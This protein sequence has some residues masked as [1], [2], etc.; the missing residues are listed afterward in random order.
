MAKYKK[1][2]KHVSDPLKKE[3]QELDLK[4]V[5]DNKYVKIIVLS[6]FVF[7]F[8]LYSNTLNH[9]YALDDDVVFL[10]NRFVQKGIDGMGDIFSHG[11]LYGF[12]NRNNQSYRPVVTAVFALEKEFFGNK[13][14]TGH[15]INVLLYGISVGVLFLLLQLLFLKQPI[16]L[17][18]L[19][20]ALFAAHPIHTE[21]VANIKGRDDMLTFFFMVL[22][23][24]WLMKFILSNNIK[25]LY[26]SLV[27]YF[28]CLLTKENAVAFIAVFP[29]LFYFFSERDLKQSII[30][31]LPYGV[32]L[33]LYFMLRN[34]VLD[35]VVFGE[36]LEVINNGLMAA[37]TTGEML[38][39]NFVILGKYVWLLIFPHPLSFDYSYSHFPIVGWTDF[40]ALGSLLVYLLLG[41]FA[42][43]KFKS[44]EVL[45]FGVLFYL[46][47]LSITSNL[48]VK[49]G[50]TLGERFLFVPS[51]GY[52]LILGVLLARMVSFKPKPLLYTVIAL[53][54][55]P[56]CL[57]TY[58]RNFE[59]KDNI[60][61]FEADV[62]AAPNSART[63]FSLGSAL[64]TNS[65]AEAD[66]AKKKVLLERAI[67]ELHETLKIYP[68]F[69]AAW[70][71][72]GVAYYSYGDYDNSRKSYEQAIELNPNEKQALNNL[73]VIY[74][75][76]REYNKALEY[77][78][79]ATVADP[80]FIDPYA[81]IGAVHHNTGNYD[82]AIAHYNK[83][84]ALQP[85]NRGV[86]NNLSKLYGTMGDQEK[87]NYY[88]K[89]LGR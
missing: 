28:V 81:N 37:T 69:T 29:L 62:D 60:T 13:P 10:K 24:Y 36:K 26:V 89:L 66:P 32:P 39:T 79:Q 48:L 63:H 11:F 54:F 86:I 75:N 1:G 64:N 30:Q 9:G 68:E 73:G 84:L 52:C 22:S 2:Q 21:V 50:C 27:C 35:D 74:F 59:W 57:K 38:A 44:K 88:S 70:Y 15:L 8:L 82:Q 5:R 12:N 25:L 51:L 65:E 61:L 14:K 87:S 41:A 17:P 3:R 20:A 23:F 83:V 55:V 40:T 19:I 53:L 46:I 71:N 72:M 7:S 42:L 34:Q 47:T 43:W 45:V 78:T 4:I 6:L 76:Q 18:A 33:L 85:G 80:S 77:F 31:A 16:W 58:S 49:I 67:K 56:F